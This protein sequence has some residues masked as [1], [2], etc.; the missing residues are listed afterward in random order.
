MGVVGCGA[1]LHAKSA[2]TALLSPLADKDNI[3]YRLQ[4]PLPTSLEEVND[5]NY[6]CQCQDHTMHRTA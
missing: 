2:A 3:C 5:T 4:I 6:Y 1:G